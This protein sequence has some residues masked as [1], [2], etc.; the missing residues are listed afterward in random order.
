MTIHILKNPKTPNYKK[1]KSLVLSLD[2]PWHNCR[3]MG[4]N[5]DGHSFSSHCF[6]LRPDDIKIPLSTS[7]HMNLCYEVLIEILKFN[8]LEVNCIFRMNANKTY[9]DS[10][11]GDKFSRMHVDH[12]WK[13]HNN[14]LIYLNN[15]GG[16]TIIPRIGKK[17]F[18]SRSHDP[19]EDD[20]IKFGG[21]VH[22]HEYPKKDPRVV[23][24]GTYM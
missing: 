19:K 11:N 24:V 1:L 4:A 9:P 2:F 6:L 5:P 21:L 16:K 10:G 7:D 13:N 14:I 23:L 17:R 20:I 3:T 12:P 22:A 18:M 15:A 8:K